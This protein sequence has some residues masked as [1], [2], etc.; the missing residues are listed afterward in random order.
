MESKNSRIG[1]YDD[2][3]NEHIFRAVEK[4]SVCLDVGCWTG[5]IGEALIKNK[6]CTIDGLDCNQEALNVA[7]RRG[8]QEVV[9]V[10]LNDK[11]LSLNTG[12]K[13]DFIIC[14]DILEHI[15]DP[16]CRLQKFSD[17]LKENGQILISVPN[18]AF[19][20]QRLAL[21]AG[22][23]NYN[24]DGGIMD[25][26][27]LRFFTFKSIKKLCS[28][29]GY[30]IIESYGYAQVKNKYFFLQ[31]LAKIWPQMFALQFFLRIKK[32]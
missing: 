26:N 19:V 23:F 30:K 31:P 1:L 29:T 13:Y 12:K 21:L 14:A 20:Q 32:K 5:N 27:H 11:N 15:V 2:C 10:D 17:L 9:C 7:K 3:F 28:K 8:Y 6:G 4:N 24:P 25:E 22:R 18:I 16:G